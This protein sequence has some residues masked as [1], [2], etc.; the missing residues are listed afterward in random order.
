MIHAHS[1]QNLITSN[2]QSH[3]VGVTNM[4]ENEESVI[5][6]EKLKL[7]E[8][9]ILSL[10]PKLQQIII[11]Q[12]FIRGVAIGLFY[13]IV[14][15]IIVQHYHKAFERFMLGELNTLLWANLIVFVLA[16]ATIVIATMKWRVKFEKLEER[17]HDIFKAAQMLRDH[18]EL[19]TK[20]KEKELE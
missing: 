19:I 17:G 2:S 3:S 13:G 12:E 20:N 7:A 9:T 18:Y 10:L 15:N 4:K 6:A 1:A 14:G 8:K 11:R 5:S 16:F